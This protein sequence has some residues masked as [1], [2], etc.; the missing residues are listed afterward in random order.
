MSNTPSVRHKLLPTCVPG[1]MLLLLLTLLAACATRQNPLPQSTPSPIAPTPTFTSEGQGVGAGVR[2]TPD[3]K[4]WHTYAVPGETPFRGVFQLLNR[5]PTEEYLLTC[6]LDYRQVPCTL[7]ERR[8]LLYRFS[9]GENEERFIPFE[10]PSLVA[11]F[12]DLTLLAISEPDVHDLEPHFRL[13]TEIGYL[14]TARAVLLVGD[15]PYQSPGL[16]YVTGRPR[17]EGTVPLNGIVVN[18]DEN[19]REFRAWLTQ[20]ARPGQSVEYFV[21]LGNDAPAAP[22]ITLAVVVFLDYQQIPLDGEEQWVT[23]VSLPS[24]TGADIPARF[25]APEEPGVH[26][27]MVVIV[28][29]P[30][31][32][33][34]DPPLGPDRHLTEYWSIVESS[35]RVAIVVEE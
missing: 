24:G 5:Q 9:M 28:Y 11:G 25:T 22:T 6:V 17:P 13:G 15:E 34:E 2:E 32:M 30:Y 33:L 27:L 4:A 29:D 35:I 21:H 3:G 14:H 20:D 7:D 23:Y 8:Q 31:R 18:Q 1:F 12:H 10:T 16:E 19:P 26:E